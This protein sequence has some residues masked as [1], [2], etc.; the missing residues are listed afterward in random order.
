MTVRGRPFP[1]GASPNPGGKPKQK[2]ITEAYR[3]LVE[4]S[5][6]ALE[7]L[8]KKNLTGADVVALAIFRQAAKGNALAAR[9][10][11][12]RLEGKVAQPVDAN[13]NLGEAF[14]GIVQALAAKKGRAS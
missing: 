3:R 6:E 2:P 10:M 14:A 1:K 4:S 8:D 13:V 7:K 9:E 11:T 5:A 12:D